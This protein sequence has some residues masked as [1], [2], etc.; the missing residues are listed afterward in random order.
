MFG[1]HYVKI[2]LAQ[3]DRDESINRLVDTMNNT[4]AFVHEA[5]PLKKIESHKRIIMLL[6]QQ[7]IECGYFIRDYAKNKN[8]CM[9]VPFA[10]D[11]VLMITFVQ[12]QEP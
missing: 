5:E 6:T 2:V 10:S 1:V 3:N 4:Y 12:G 11:G 8:F 9:L 7:T